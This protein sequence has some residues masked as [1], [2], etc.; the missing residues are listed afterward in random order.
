MYSMAREA[1]TKDKQNLKIAGGLKALLQ[2]R[3]DKL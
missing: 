3:D 2:I 1:N